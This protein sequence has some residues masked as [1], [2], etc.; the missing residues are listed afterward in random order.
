[1]VEITVDRFSSLVTKVYDG[2]LEP[3]VWSTVVQDLS[4]LLDGTTISL[5]A[6][7]VT[8]RTGLGIITSETDDSFQRAYSDYYATRNVWLEQLN[9][10]PVGST[11]HTDDFYARRDLVK[12]EFYND[13]LRRQDFVAAGALVLKRAAGSVLVLSA[14]MR[15][16]QSE[17]QTANMRRLFDLL[18]PH[19]LRSIDTMAYVPRL[20]PGED[21]RDTVEHGSDAL[22]FLDR[23]GRVTHA[24]KAGTRMR[25]I[26]TDLYC[27]RTGRLNMRDPRAD[28]ALR[29]ALQQISNAEYRQLK[30]D[31][32]I[33]RKG[34]ASSSATIV[35]FRNGREQAIF[36]GIF[37]SRPI[38]M[39][40]V[41]DP[42]ATA[43]PTTLHG[44]GLT[45]AEISL[46]LAIAQ[47]MSPRD[48]AEARGV[49]LH[50][51]RTQLKSVYAKTDT[52]R[53]S[54]LVAL[55]LSG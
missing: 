54:Q 47:G 30:G 4:T 7:D 48:Y 5:Q 37:E 51:V 44:F 39:L 20:S 26:G 27:D 34:A 12:T 35:P 49:S 31:F 43:L 28:L 19:I 24:N 9:D 42:S 50:T 53:Q 1:M 10:I 29:D 41:R 32:A 36:K 16:D 6:H 15:D 25:Q 55:A 17:R 18:G 11:I 3:A 8:G 45:P 46:A 2:G 21:Y 52:N 38:A 14:T 33:R 22:F 40:L 13:F 23:S